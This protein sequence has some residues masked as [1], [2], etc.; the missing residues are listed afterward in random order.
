MANPSTTYFPLTGD[1]AV[2]AL[3]T[4]YKWV[5]DSSRIVDFSIS[6]GFF[7]EY[8]NSPSE[9]ANYVGAALGTFSYYSNIKFN[10][11][12]GFNNPSQAAAS[13]SEINVSL[14]GANLFFSNPNQYARAFFPSPY[15]Q[16]AV[17]AGEEGDV[18]LNI[19]SPANSL[20][21]YGPG[22]QGWF[23]LIHELGH[24]VGLKHTHDDG[25]TGR[26]TFAQ[27][28]ISWLDKDYGSI[29]SYN[30]DAAW[31]TVAWDPATPMAADVLA[32]QYLYGKNL[33]TNA[34]DSVFQLQRTNFFYTLWDASGTD[35]IDAS[36]S[37]EGWYILLPDETV[38]T[39]VDTKVGYSLPTSDYNASFPTDFV[40]LTGDYENATGSSFNDV[41]VGN[42]FDNI[43]CNCPATSTKLRPIV[44]VQSG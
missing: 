12:G 1:L 30:D 35:T 9:V 39:L 22:S 37:S 28:G 2:D 16:T 29:M 25:G 33:S 42:R 19:L 44:I 32:L 23:V 21:S 10:Y 36:G 14:D 26:P 34:G 31:N 13:G 6:N 20:P 41:I 18:Y 43:I 4:G 7:G 3:T 15:D 5:L 38:S 8:W 40:W 17:Y 24:A 11:V 27:L